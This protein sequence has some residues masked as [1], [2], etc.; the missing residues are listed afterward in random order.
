MA[1]Q[2]Q[3]CRAGIV[4]CGNHARYHYQGYYGSSERGKM[5][6]A[7]DVVEEKLGFFRNE[8]L[9]TYSS[10]TEMLSNE[11]LELVHVVVPPAY[12]TPAMREVFEA[13]VP[14]KGIFLEKPM[15]TH[16]GEADE[17]VEECGRRGIK[18]VVGHQ[19][20]YHPNWS[21]PRTLIDDGVI[22]QVHLIRAVRHGPPI[23]THH[24]HQT[25][26]MLYYLAD[27]TVKWVLG[28]IHRDGSHVVEGI[29]AEKQALGY[30]QF[31]NG[32]FGLIEAGNYEPQ[33]PGQ[34]FIA[35]E[36]GDIR[37]INGE[38]QYRNST[39]GGEWKAVE[40][41]EQPNIID[42]WVKWIEGGPEHRCSGRNGHATLEALMA[43]Y[44]S[45]RTRGRVELPL[46]N[47]G[48]AFEEMRAAGEIE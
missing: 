32:A 31:E 4:G 19:L 3:I 33:S 28:Q 5:V 6:A 23:L 15:T 11:E 22:G 36:D 1:T 24:T 38:T 13:D 39:T 18:L 46:Q 44:E 27:S 20:R 40:A 10:A 47:R 16:L 45:S 43:I 41:V 42:D 2:Q 12:H 9:S 7:A 8:G 30:L 37:F 34:I 48:N 29:E 25:N 35:G 17:I 26:L 14:L 21:I